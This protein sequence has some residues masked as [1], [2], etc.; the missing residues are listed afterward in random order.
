[1]ELVPQPSKTL[2]RTIYT[3]NDVIRNK[4]NLV[5]EVRE[6]ETEQRR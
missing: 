4:S 3:S 6:R 2:I 5:K 1:M